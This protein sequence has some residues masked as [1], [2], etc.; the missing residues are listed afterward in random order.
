VPDRSAPQL[1]NRRRFARRQWARRWLTWRYVVG[2]VAV[3]LVIGFGVYA[4]YFSPWLRV[5]GV[6]VLGESQ[7]SEDVILSTADVPTDTALA[8]VDLAAIEVRVRS[9]AAIEE[10]EVTRRWPH[11][12]RIEV[13]ERTPIAVTARGDRF[14]QVDETGVTFGDLAEP[15]RGLPRVVTGPGASTEALAEAAAVVDALPEE[16]VAAVDHVEVL[17]V[18]TIRLQLRDSRT[19]RWGSAELSEDKAEVLL[20]LFEAE[21]SGEVQRARLYD[22]SVPGRPTTRR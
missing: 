20:A 10:V 13:V 21:R 7:L 5:D 1:R 6:E 16:L 4:V 3:L 17:T 14:T 2:A 11:R 15:P 12:V 18:D 22:V 9:L 8:G 19:V